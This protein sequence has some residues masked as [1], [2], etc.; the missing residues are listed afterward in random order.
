MVELV[1]KGRL[2]DRLIEKGFLTS[3]HLQ[4]ALSEQKRF[5]R[6]LGQ[7]LV[8]LGF[9]RAADITAL[10]A[11]DFGL[12]FLRA[13]DVDPDP[14]ILSA[15]DPAFVRETL[16]FPY[17]MEDGSLRVVVVFVSP[18]RILPARPVASEK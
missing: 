10:L 5:H 8:S 3:E 12:E 14:L 18:L 9:A 17:R 11:E 1:V 15:I 13:R 16:A 4:V 7:I 6:P 2:G